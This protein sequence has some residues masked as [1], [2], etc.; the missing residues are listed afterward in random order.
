MGGGGCSK[1][2]CEER[3]PQKGNPNQI[4]DLHYDHLGRGILNNY[5]IAAHKDYNGV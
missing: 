3:L 4:G 5:H 1:G 2:P